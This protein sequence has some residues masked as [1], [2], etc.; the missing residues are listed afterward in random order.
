MKRPTQAEV[1]EICDVQLP[2]TE[3][4]VDDLIEL[5]IEAVDF[6]VIMRPLSRPEYIEYANGTQHDST[7][8]N[9]RAQAVAR[10]VL[11]PKR[12]EINEAREAFAGLDASITRQ[13]ERCAGFTEDKDEEWHRLDA[14]TDPDLLGEL[15]IPAAVAADLCARYPS[16]GHLWICRLRTL[17]VVFIMH[18]LGTRATE[19]LYNKMKLK[20]EF[21]GACLNA[22]VDAVAWPGPDAMRAAFERYPAIP[23][24]V[25]VPKLATLSKSVAVDAAKKFVRTGRRTAI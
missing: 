17:G 11:W 7:S 25:I 19:A 18:R 22:A 14:S 8:S 5:E 12:S 23:P 13:I 3:F 16:P 9:A 15:G 21:Y 2:K 10:A 4:G 1:D 24:T 6:V 20:G